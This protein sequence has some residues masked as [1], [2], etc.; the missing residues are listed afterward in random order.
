[1]SDALHALARRAEGDRFFLASLLATYARSEG[2]DD[3]GLAAALGCSGED[4]T[5]LRLCRAPRS[6]AHEFWHD[7]T[8]I[9]ERFRLEPER[10]AE[11][12]KRGLV[13]RRFQSAPPAGGF[14]MAARDGEDEPAED[15][16]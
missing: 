4:L 7:V 1:M 10:L 16:P 6:D 15:E 8:R 14:L 12:V 2:L 9:A 3:A 5:M 13:L 11:A